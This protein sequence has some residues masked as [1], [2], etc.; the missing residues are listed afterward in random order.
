M[1]TVRSKEEDKEKGQIN[2]ALIL[3]LKMN[4][5]SCFKMNPADRP[6]NT[7]K[8]FEICGSTVPY[9][10]TLVDRRIMWP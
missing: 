10:I 9:Y 6:F 2:F 1:T 8:E 3:L 5:V 7:S 4:V